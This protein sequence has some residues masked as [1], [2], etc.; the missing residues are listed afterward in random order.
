MHNKLVP[1]KYV[2]LN[3]ANNI[4]QK[5]LN[6]YKKLLFYRRAEQHVRIELGIAMEF[7]K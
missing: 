4:F 7:S 3:N 1:T 6:H 2:I 5:I